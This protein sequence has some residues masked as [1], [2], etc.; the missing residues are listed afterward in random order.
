MGQTQPKGACPAQGWLGVQGD[1]FFWEGLERASGPSG[2]GWKWVDIGIIPN[3][4]DQNYNLYYL[5]I[6]I[7]VYILGIGITDKLYNYICMR[8][9]AII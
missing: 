5:G 6:Y 9:N 8:H 1:T 7:H 4:H 3:I 2:L